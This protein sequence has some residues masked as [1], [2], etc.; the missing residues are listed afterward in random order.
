MSQQ[1][2]LHIRP[3]SEQLVTFNLGGAVLIAGLRLYSKSR[4][5]LYEVPLEGC[6][7]IISNALRL[8]SMHGFEKDEELL[9]VL[10]DGQYGGCP[11]E[12]LA[13]LL[14]ELSEAIPAEYHKQLLID[15]QI[16]GCDIWVAEAQKMHE[17]IP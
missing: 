1:P 10:Q 2:V 3:G 14:T 15:L 5:E 8:A 7:R 17:A 9:R 11:D 16:P 12:H 6:R 4:C 13:L